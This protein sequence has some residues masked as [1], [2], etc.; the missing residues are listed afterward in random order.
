MTIDI[1]DLRFIDATGGV[2]IFATQYKSDRDRLKTAIVFVE[3]VRN[4]N[5]RSRRGERKYDL[6]YHVSSSFTYGS[7]RGPQ[8]IRSS[9]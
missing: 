5:G 1:C 3:G 8:Q 6:T 7:L 4:M 9:A 2:T